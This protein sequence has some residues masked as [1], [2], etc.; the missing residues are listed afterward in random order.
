MS[1]F[2]LSYSTINNS[3][4]KTT[5]VK[6]TTKGSLYWLQTSLDSHLLCSLNVPYC[7]ISLKH[8][9][10]NLYLFNL[11]T[12][13]NWKVRTNF[14][15]KFHIP[16][17]EK[18]PYQHMSWKVYFVSYR[19]KNTVVTYLTLVINFIDSYLSSRVMDCLLLHIV[20][21]PTNVLLMLPVTVHLQ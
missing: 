19:C 12:E 9:L 13:C 20:G 17:Q 6:E 14:W 21:R 11:H 18:C 5:A 15:H 7:N 16:K 4:Q 8:I 2:K 1:I 10:H 3:L